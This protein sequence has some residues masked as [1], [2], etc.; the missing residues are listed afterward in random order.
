[1]L[2]ININK[3]RHYYNKN[4]Y[5]VIKNFMN[6]QMKKD[7]LL[8]VNQ[9]EKY[10]KNPNNIKSKYLNQYIKSNNKIILHTTEYI[11]NNHYGI[12]NILTRGILP[13]V[14]EYINNSKVY[15]HNEKIN[16]NYNNTGFYK[17]HQD[18]IKYSNNKNYII[19]M[20]NLSNT[21]LLNGCIT[22]SPISE[23]KIL[24]HEN[25]IISNTYKLDWINCFTRFGDI[26]LFN[27]YI[28][29]KISINKSY[30]PRKAL[31]ITYNNSSDGDLRDS[32]YKNIFQK[33][34]NNYSNIINN[35][36]SNIINNNYSNISD[37]NYSNISDNI[38]M[39][40]LKINSP[41]NQKI[42]NKK[43]K[44]NEILKLYIIKGDKKYDMNITHIQHAL[45]ITQLAKNNNETNEFQLLCFIH[46]IGYLIK[47]KHYDEYNI[48]N[49]Y[50]QKNINYENKYFSNII[51]MPIIY[52][53]LAKRYLCTIDDSYYS[54]LS[55]ASKKSFFLQ[56][57]Y[58]DLLSLKLI[59][60]IKHN[61][62]FNDSIKLRKYIDLSK[63]Q[64][65]YISIDLNYINN[66]LHD[67]IL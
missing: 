20:I 2:N 25:G 57:G 45:K 21:N 19:C 58:L 31:Y 41:Y 62:Y 17:P 35:N 36:Y 65:I 44:I 26:I 46:N 54:N 60:N 15:L 34:N 1:M 29:H 24:N 5:V 52:N 63:K 39:N 56:N 42:N 30:M 33:Y 28:P 43:N 67:F 48:N 16:Y 40:Y 66:L 9:I 13:K 27:S 14:V 10:N 3:L 23:K 22:F 37:N 12:K 4:G 6:N 51:T 32:Y 55:E 8:Y 47:N 38:N 11:I 18:I 7:L 61:I 59:N 50:L 64:S 49:N 53:I